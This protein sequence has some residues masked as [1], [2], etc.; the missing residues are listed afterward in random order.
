M[1][2]LSLSPWKKRSSSDFDVGIG[3]YDGAET[4]DLVGLLLLSQVQD[5]GLSIGLFRDDGIAL[6]RLTERQ[7]E[8]VKTKLIRVFERHNLKLEIRV[9]KTVVNY[10]DITLDLATG[11]Y[12][13]YMKENDQPSYVHR[14]SNHPPG[15]LRNIPKNINDRL[16]RIS[17]SEAVFEAA[18][19]VYQEALK[20]AG[21]DHK[22]KF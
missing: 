6:S 12:R 4:C 16:S 1:V 10:L 2:S 13:P 18:A 14:L 7:T 17:S 9:N 3:S 8:K 22:L 5:L 15:I 21:Y 19:P 20:R 11:E